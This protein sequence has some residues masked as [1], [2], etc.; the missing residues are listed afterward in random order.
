MDS[1]QIPPANHHTACLPACLPA[2]HSKP[3]KRTPKM[4]HSISI[5]I[6]A[7]TMAS[8]GIDIKIIAANLS[9]S[10]QIIQYW[11]KKAMDRGYNP[12][13]DPRIYLEYVE[14]GK[15]SGHPKEITE[16]IKEGILDSIRKD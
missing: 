6:Q 3:L 15:R 5:C 13:V 12:A 4:P 7:L 9:L 11:V 16:A 8:L 2:S 1:T 14:D 10:R